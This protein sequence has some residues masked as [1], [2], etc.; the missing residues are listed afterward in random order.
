MKIVRFL[1]MLLLIQGVI[2][3]L[4]AQ[5]LPVTGRV[6]GPNGEPLVGATISVKGTTTSTTTNEGGNFSIT[7]P[8]R[9]AVLVVTYA[10]MEPKEMSVRSAGALNFSLSTA[11][12]SLDEVVVPFTETVAP[13]NGSPFGPVTFPVTG[14]VCAKSGE[15][16]PCRRRSIKRKRTI[17][18][19]IH[20]L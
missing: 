8:Q 7:A 3:P 1:W 2:S 18:I 16:P 12:G 10:G 19:F 13:T 11:A 6:T 4:F 15:M 14:R 5:T 20:K 9:G 17:F